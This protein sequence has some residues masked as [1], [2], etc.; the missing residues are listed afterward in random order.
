VELLRDPVLLI[1]NPAARRSARLHG[2][3]LEAF[4][5]A[6][7]RCDAM[8]T[9]RPGHAGDIASRLAGDYRAVFTLGGD[10]TAMEVVGALARTGTPVG[11]LA[12]GTGNLVARSLGIPL[13]VQR[14]VPRLLA[15]TEAVIDLGVLHDG[16]RFA[17]SAGVGVDAALIHETP[18]ALKRRFG[19]LAYAFTATRASLRRRPFRVTVEVDGVTIERE[20]AA[21]MVANFG[22]VLNDL[23]VLGP[24]IAYD[25]GT[26]DLCVFSPR[27]TADALRIGWRLFRK[28]FGTDPALLYKPGRTFRVSCD[29][30]QIYQ[31]D[32]EILGT[33][34]FE[35]RVDPLAAHILLPRLASASP[36]EAE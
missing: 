28:D 25:D 27:G 13:R 23:L 22:S 1:A 24:G 21:V 33:T 17:F 20:A 11:I 36:G 15:G 16:R 31:A 8:L 18:P 9:E 34:P 7:V 32:G 26:L 12:G 19:I 14:A 30:P 3:V 10:G 6:G 35:V 4:R 5:R 2:A 29:P